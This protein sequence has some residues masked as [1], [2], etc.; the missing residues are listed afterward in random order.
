MT[1]TEQ[2]HEKVLALKQMLD[3]KH[4]GMENWLRDIHQNLQKDENLVQVLT[5]EEIGVI[6][7]GL[8]LKAKQV[9]VSDIVNGKGKKPASQLTLDDL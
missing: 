7:S 9:I 5:P 2:I 3:T 8:S 6:V 1:H 4:P